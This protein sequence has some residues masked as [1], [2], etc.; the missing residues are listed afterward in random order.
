M[1]GRE[2][3]GIREKGEVKEGR[4]PLRTNAHPYRSLD[5]CAVSKS[6][7]RSAGVFTTGQ[8]TWGD[9]YSQE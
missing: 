1:R 2:G 9:S 5:V 4:S 8:G 3:R 6:D 7:A